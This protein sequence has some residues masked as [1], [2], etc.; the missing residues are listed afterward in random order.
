[1]YKP[2]RLHRK[3]SPLGE[4]LFRVVTDAGTFQDSEIN[5]IEITGGN[6][7]ANPAISPS[8]AQFSIGGAVTI[9]RDT[10]VHIQLSDWFANKI[11]S[12]GGATAAQVK[13]RFKGRKGLTEVDDL[14]WK[15]GKVANFNTTVSASS[16]TSLLR[17]AKRTTSPVANENILTALL[18]AA[19][20]PA[21]G[22]RQTVDAPG[23][24]TYDLVFANDPDLLFSDV[25]TKYGTDLG[26]FLQQRRNG[27]LRFLSI[28][29]RREQLFEGVATQMPLLRSQVLSPAKWSQ[30]IESASNQLVNVRRLADG[31]EFRQDW[32]LPSGTTPVILEAREVD[33]LHIKTATENYR[34]LM[35]ALNNQEN[36]GRVE[37][38]SVKI[39]M[40][41]LLSSSKQVDRLVGAQIL[42]MQPGDLVYL[43]YDWPVAIQAPYYA[44]Q[45][46]ETITPDTWEFELSLY[47]PRDVVGTFDGDLPAVPARVWDSMVYPWD[48]ETREWNKI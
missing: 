30:N 37:L 20:H 39:D 31:S 16:W 24:A 15:I 8:V 12:Y 2:R 43:S 42:A 25:V 48:A 29:R 34:Y 1:M 10:S 4:P 44:N 23:A 6:A 3:L 38:E 32:P 17:V 14:A 40:I 36:T 47:H 46:K 21:I 35:N 19:N 9:N 22:S 13:D 26:T 28:G 45:I 33:M 7:D 18:R 27:S 5:A 11:G 41:L